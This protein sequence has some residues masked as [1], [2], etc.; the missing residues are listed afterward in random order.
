MSDIDCGMS[1]ALRR[2]LDRHITG[3]WGEDSVPPE[4]KR[5][6][7]RR[8]RFIDVAVRMRGG[9][10]PA[11]YK[12]CFYCQAQFD[13]QSLAWMLNGQPAPRCEVTT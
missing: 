3:S 1:A 9:L 2:D 12:R 4:P 10:K 7:R 13:K 6:P 11:P 5:A 8:H